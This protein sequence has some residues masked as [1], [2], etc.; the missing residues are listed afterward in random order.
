M[1]RLY[2]LCL[3]SLNIGFIQAQ[4]IT[5]AWATLSSSDLPYAISI[6]ASGNVYTANYGNNT[7]S[8]ITSDGTAIPE[9]ATLASD[10]N[11]SGIAVDASGNVY[12]ANIN[13]GTVTKVTSDGTVI[14]AWA[15][16]ASNALPYAIATDASGNVYTANDNNTVSKITSEGIVTQAWATL[17]NNALPYAIAIDALGNVYTANYGNNT[18]SKITSAG[19][20]A[21]AWGLLANNARPYGIALDASGNVYTANFGNNTVSK[22]TSAGIVTQAWATLVRGANP[23]SIVVDTSGNVY[24]A[25]YANS[26]ISKITSAGIVVQAWVTLANNTL[27]YA[28]ALD[29]SGNVYTANENNTISKIVP[30]SATPITLLSFK[31]DLKNGIA[32]LA[33]ETG[34]ENNFN[35]FEIQKSSHDSSS[36]FLTQGEIPAKGSNSSYVYAVPQSETLAYYRLKIIDD[37]GGY[38][39]G[40]TITLYK[41][42]SNAI[43][44]N[45]A[46]TYINI[47]A[48]KESSLSIYDAGGRFIKTQNVQIGN[49]VIDV[50][51]LASGVYFIVSDDNQKRAFIKK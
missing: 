14:Q 22:I 19:I 50:H 45:P 8:K 36:S 7:V 16:L 33:W 20:A 3:L 28:I 25:N 39:Y 29:A 43:Y 21:T 12:T 31:G 35:H 5:Q 26:T 30:L 18:V 32:S 47:K 4:I 38:K 23:S 46:K 15:T 37:D 49:N 34:V 40:N 17:A 11:P 1:K 10:A 6:D 9:W 48:A 51:S 44:P 13:N 42:V 27:P 24:T 2:I 41:Q